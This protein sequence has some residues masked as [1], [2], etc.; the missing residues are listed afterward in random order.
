[1]RPEDEVRALAEV[2]SR[3]EEDFPDVEGSLVEDAVKEAHHRLTGPI[4]DFVPVLVEREARDR[5][6]R[7]GS[8]ARDTTE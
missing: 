4:R 3:L 2:K 8:G 1:M 7:V 5:L 6:A